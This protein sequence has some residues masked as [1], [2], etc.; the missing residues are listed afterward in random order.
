MDERQRALLELKRR[1][2][3]ATPD[4]IRVLD[5]AWVCRGE[6]GGLVVP[7]TPATIEQWMANAEAGVYGPTEHALL[8]KGFTL[9]K[10]PPADFQENR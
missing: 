1:A 4:E 10:E 8:S 3:L 5:S 2:G 6:T 9:A 7:P